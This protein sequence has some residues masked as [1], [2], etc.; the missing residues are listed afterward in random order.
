MFHPQ[1]VY[2]LAYRLAKPVCFSPGGRMESEALHVV[3][4]KDVPRKFVY[5]ADGIPD[6]DVG[7]LWLKFWA[8]SL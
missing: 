4:H 1:H 7:L 2:Y 3:Y 5:V 6:Y 8:P